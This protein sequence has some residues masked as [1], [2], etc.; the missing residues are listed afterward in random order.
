MTTEVIY[1]I[2]LSLTFNSIIIIFFQNIKKK[3]NLYDIPDSKRKLHKRK[4]PLFGGLFVF[5]NLVFCFLEIVLLMGD[6]T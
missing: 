2:F 5:I 3:I 4:V 6:L 1:S